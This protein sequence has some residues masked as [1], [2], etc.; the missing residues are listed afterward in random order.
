[1]LNSDSVPYDLG[2][3][4]VEFT[5]RTKLHGE[6]GEYTMEPGSRLKVEIYEDCGAMVLATFEARHAQEHVTLFK[7]DFRR[8]RQGTGT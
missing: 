5:K 6:H 3:Y 8:L 4:T 1:M 2:K 7:R